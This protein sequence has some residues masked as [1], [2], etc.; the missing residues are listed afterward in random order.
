MTEAN[1]LH[2]LLITRPTEKPNLAAFTRPPKI[3]TIDIETSPNIAYTWG[4]W[5]QNVSLSQLIES[6]RVL[7]FA[8]KWHDKKTVEFYS[9]YHDGRETMIRKA[10]D[11]LNEADIIVSYNGPAF[12]IKH[13]QREFV[14]AGMTPPSP[15]RNI[16]LLKTARAQFKFPSNKLDHVAD[17]M[18]LGQ[19]LKHAGQE[20]WNQV[21]AGNPKAWTEMKRYNV[22]DVRLTEALYDYLG[23]WIKGAPHAGLW[24]TE[25]SCHACAS[26]NL[27]HDG[28]HY[29]NTAV[30]ARLH[31]LDCG[32]WN[33][34]TTNKL[35]TETKAL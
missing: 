22:Q 4:L 6:S 17:A 13:L 24:A 28:W 3:L 5:N 2:K 14:T 30:Y 11:L 20:L 21:L 16:D 18:G 12:D 15:F 23:P 9:E 34:L 32:A 26:T 29:T 35:R 19:K 10:W 27:T 33:R 25:R 7:C 1:Q 8:A 31:C